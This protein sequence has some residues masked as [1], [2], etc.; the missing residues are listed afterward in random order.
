MGKVYLNFIGLGHTDFEPE[1]YD[2]NWASSDNADFDDANRWKIKIKNSLLIKILK[3][4][5]RLNMICCILD[6]VSLPWCTCSNAGMEI[7]KY[8]IYLPLKMTCRCWLCLSSLHYYDVES[9]NRRSKTITE[10][11]NVLKHLT[12]KRKEDLQ[13]IW[14]MV[15]H[16]WAPS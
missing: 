11:W 9:V 13:V 15:L 1:L 10:Q 14:R 2:S 12:D 3:L 4:V 8:V 6:L 5:C 16:Y 7:F